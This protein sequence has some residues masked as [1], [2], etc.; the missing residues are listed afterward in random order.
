M[1]FISGPVPRA[2]F[3]L[4]GFALSSCSDKIP[5]ENLKISETIVRSVK[6]PDGSA[7][8]GKY[9]QFYAR[10][11]TDKIAYVFAYA[12]PDAEPSQ[13]QNCQ[14]EEANPLYCHSFHA[15]D[16]KWVKNV[17]YLPDTSGGGCTYIRGLY[18]V[19][20]NMNVYIRC[21]GPN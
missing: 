19:K 5:D 2:F 12:D 7:E 21:N 13:S 11:G 4:F 8:I 1:K 14:K 15:G 3:I 18:D 20:L 6:L 9:G 16:V 17:L 10:I